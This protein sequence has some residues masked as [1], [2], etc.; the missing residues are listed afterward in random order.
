[1]KRV[2]RFAYDYLGS[3]SSVTMPPILSLC[4]IQTIAAHL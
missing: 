1:M 4:Y 2:T 3:P